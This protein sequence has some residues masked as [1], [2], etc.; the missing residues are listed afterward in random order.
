MCIRDST[1]Q[2]ASG[3]NLV[4][5]EQNYES[6]TG[7]A[8]LRISYAWKASWGVLIP[9]LRGSYVREFEDATEVFGVRFAGDPFNGSANPTPPIFV[10]TD[11][12]DESYFRIAAGFSAQL[13]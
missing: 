13:P 7:S 1:E 10:Q 12:P 8:G 11:A 9:H 6:A 5:D 2:G 4:Y 3:L